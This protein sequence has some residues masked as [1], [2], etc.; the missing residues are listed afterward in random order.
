[1]WEKGLTNA[2]IC[3]TILQAGRQAGRHSY[4]YV[5]MRLFVALMVGI[6]VI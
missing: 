2:M 1:M 4:N 3:A 5:A 6:T